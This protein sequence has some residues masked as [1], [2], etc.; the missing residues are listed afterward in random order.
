MPKL[1]L[2]SL[3]DGINNKV[4]PHLARSTEAWFMCNIDSHTLLGAIQRSKGA[5][6]QIGNTIGVNAIRGM[7]RFDYV[8]GDELKR[9]LLI[10]SG[11]NLYT[12]NTITNVFDS[13]V[14][15]LSL[16]KRTYF[17]TANQKTYFV[18]GV[19]TVK[20][21][22][23]NESTNKVVDFQANSSFNP[24]AQASIIENGVKLITFY[25]EQLYLVI[26]STAYYS[27][28]RTDL[29]LIDFHPINQ[30][31]TFNNGNGS[32]IVAVKELNDFLYFFKE[33]ECW[34]IDYN[35][36]KQKVGNFGTMSQDSIVV[37]HDEMFYYNRNG[38]YRF[39]S[40][41]P[42][43]R[44]IENLV[45]GIQDPYKVRGGVHNDEFLV[46]YVGDV[47]FEG[48]PYKDMLM[49]YEI[50][51]QKWYFKSN[52]NVSSMTTFVDST[53]QEKL[54]LGSQDG[55]V[56]EHETGYSPMT[57]PNSES[58]YLFPRMYLGT[59]IN[60]VV[61]DDIRIYC[62]AEN[63]E[64]FKVMIKM[65]QD[66]WVEVGTLAS[67]VNIFRVPGGDQRMINSLVIKLVSVG[68]AKTQ[69]VEKLIINYTYKPSGQQSSIGDV[70][71][72][73]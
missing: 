72:V 60:P 21:Y 6:I 17:V 61:V 67:P 35:Q 57:E 4:S 41:V 33:H 29:D 23:P 59:Q 19:D 54:Y 8:S 43:S 49:I 70:V 34:R 3:G 31:V 13:L 56:F 58:T 65:D 47:L 7:H 15:N 66:D 62:N 71:N 64:R 18:N 44:K 1:T 68:D 28:L 36:N 10:V 32:D 63:N 2:D 25:R 45:R 38:F 5:S 20:I 69:S 55:K 51:T 14:A 27:G 24:N 48:T 39:G 16:D 30:F 50:A 42:I 11:T 46:W 22:D 52:Y 40:V 37:I 26:G 9:E 53:G 12:L 73:N